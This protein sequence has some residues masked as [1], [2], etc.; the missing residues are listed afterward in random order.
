MEPNLSNIFAAL[1]LKVHNHVFEWTKK[2]S[3]FF[4]M[5]INASTMH[6]NCWKKF[7]TF[8]ANLAYFSEIGILMNFPFSA[9]RK[10]HLY[11]NAIINYK[12]K[13]K[14]RQSKTKYKFDRKLEWLIGCCA[15]HIHPHQVRTDVDGFFLCMMLWNANDNE[16][17]I[18]LWK[19]YIFSIHFFLSQSKSMQL[20]CEDGST[21]RYQCASISVYIFWWFV[22]VGWSDGYGMYSVITFSTHL[23][24]W[25]SP[26]ASCIMWM[27]M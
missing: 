14:I 24:L 23:H 3:S 26:I 16:Y 18:H 12:K 2:C 25:T 27:V 19:E 6:W 4:H 8:S 15:Q 13:K 9:S 11:F 20:N 17:A 5:S 1:K 22:N 10:H 7:A 21:R